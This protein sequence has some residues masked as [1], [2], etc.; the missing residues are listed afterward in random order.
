VI[1]DAAIQ[2][3]NAIDSNCSERD[4]SGNAVSVFLINALAGQLRQRPVGS[5]PPSKAAPRRRPSVCHCPQDGG[6]LAR[7]AVE[8][9]LQ[10]VAERRV[11]LAGRRSPSEIQRR[12]RAAGGSLVM[13]STPHAASCAF[14]NLAAERAPD[15]GD[16]DAAVGDRV[17]DA[18]LRVFIA[19]LPTT[20]GRR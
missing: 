20:S 5:R 12:D 4:A 8:R 3:M 6:D 10:P 9:F 19:V 11:R 18:A 1:L 2:I 15:E 13:G 16:V 17:D 7:M 14:A